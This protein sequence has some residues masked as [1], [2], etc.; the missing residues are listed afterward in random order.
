MGT[1]THAA[2]VTWEFDGLTGAHNL[3]STVTFNAGG[4]TLTADAF[5]F[6]FSALGWAAASVR[7]TKDGLG[8]NAQSNDWYRPDTINVMDVLRIQLPTAPDAVGLVL[9]T[10]QKSPYFA[11]WTNNDGALPGLSEAN[12]TSL[13]KGQLAKGANTLS[14]AGGT[15]TYLF[16]TGDYRMYDVPDPKRWDKKGYRLSSLSLTT[17][18]GSVVNGTTPLPPAMGL[19]ATAIAVL[20]LF[21]ARSRRS[22]AGR[23]AM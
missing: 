9:S 3:G 10:K 16:L 19:F 15:S 4:V 23:P 6:D 13:A 14:I 11:A 22:G 5:V 1:P 7:Q 2:S 17:S 8:V 20:G 12:G 18:D 21:G